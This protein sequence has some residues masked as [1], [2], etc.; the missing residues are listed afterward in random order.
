MLRRSRVHLFLLMALLATL[1]DSTPVTAAVAAPG[2]LAAPASVTVRP[3]DTLRSLAAR[4]HLPVSTLAADN[5]LSAEAALHPDGVLRLTPPAVPLPGFGS[6]AATPTPATLGASYRPGCPVGPADLRLLS[7]TYYGFDLTA[8]TG[9]LVVHRDLQA[10]AVAVFGGL[11]AMRFPVQ[12]L[13]LAQLTPTDNKFSST[14]AFNCRTVAGSTELSQHAY[15]LALDINSVQNPMVDGAIVVPPTGLAFRDRSV[16]APGM[17]HS[18]GAADVLRGHGLH[19]GGSWSAKK[20]YMH[21]SV[22]GR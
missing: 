15:G 8:H 5:G 17:M 11:Y 21:W 6:A 14:A 1:T 16:Y 10:R 19:W 20:D 4:A 2:A 18:P 3:G 22:N 9:Y 12:H 13:V 7:L